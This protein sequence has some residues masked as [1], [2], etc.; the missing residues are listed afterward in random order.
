M[1][2]PNRRLIAYL[3]AAILATVL[4]LA[5]VLSAD[6]APGGCISHVEPGVEPVPVCQVLW[7]PVVSTGSTTGLGGGQ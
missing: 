7:L 6:A 1:Q 3:L 5:I 4:A 2:D